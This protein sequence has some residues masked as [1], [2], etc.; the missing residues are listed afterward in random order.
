MCLNVQRLIEAH[1]IVIQDSY[2]SS[3]KNFNPFRV[4][5]DVFE[6]FSEKAEGNRF[7]VLEGLIDSRETL[8][9]ILAS[10]AANI[11]RESA[12]QAHKNSLHTI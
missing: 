7:V 3:K 12:V 9:R 11:R 5:K 4:V 8:A 10:S 2:E 1:D 6:E